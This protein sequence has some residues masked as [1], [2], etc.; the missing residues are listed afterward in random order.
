M[1]IKNNLREQLSS[2]GAFD[3]V[4]IEIS[5]CFKMPL[6]CIAQSLAMTPTPIHPDGL[7]AHHYCYYY[8]YYHLGEHFENLNKTINTLKAI[9]PYVYTKTWN[10][11]QFN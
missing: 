2:T 3:A 1:S 11:F 5:L 8:Y 4:S 6:Q 10:H 7:N 9:K